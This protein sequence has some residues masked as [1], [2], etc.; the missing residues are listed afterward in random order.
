MDDDAL[1]AVGE[2][3]SGERAD[4]FAAEAAALEF[5]Q[6]TEGE[7]DV[8]GEFVGT[9]DQGG[10]ADEARRRAL[11]FAGD[12][13]PAV[14]ALPFGILLKRGDGPFEAGLLE[15]RRWPVRFVRYRDG[16]EES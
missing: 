13:G 6:Q 7:F 4:G 8:A 11:A 3:P 14:P 2:G 10:E 12:D 5:R 9:A 1:G 16:V 15:R